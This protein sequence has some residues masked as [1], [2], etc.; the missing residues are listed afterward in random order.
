MDLTLGQKDLFESAW[1]VYGNGGRKSTL[2][3]HKLIQGFVQYGEDRRE[4]YSHA[5]EN[6]K[7]RYTPE[8]FE[9]VKNQLPTEE[10]FK[11]CDL[12]LEG[13]LLKAQ[14]LMLS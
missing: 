12:V 2:L 7:E 9:R 14:E 6:M 11:F 8:E 1:F 10:C 3:N 5:E 4:A 13:N